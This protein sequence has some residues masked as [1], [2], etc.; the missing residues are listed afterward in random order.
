MV[1]RLTEAVQGGHGTSKPLEELA[2]TL[3]AAIDACEDPQDLERLSRR[4]LECMSQLGWTRDEA[5]EDD[6]RPFRDLGSASLR[7]L[8]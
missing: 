2:E 4:F 1:R 7:D 8:A 5:S 3:A 6:V